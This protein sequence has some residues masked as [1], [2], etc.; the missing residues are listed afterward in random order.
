MALDIT[1]I[2]D[3][4]N[5]YLNSI[6]STS[7]A[8]SE[9]QSIDTDYGEIFKKYLTKAVEDESAN[10]A[11]AVNATA[12]EALAQTGSNLDIVVN[13]SLATKINTVF[14]GLDIQSEIAENMASHTVDIS[15]QIAQNIDSHSRLDEINAAALQIQEVTEAAETNTD[16]AGS[17]E[18]SSNADAYSG[19]LGTSALQRLA[20]SSYFSANLIQSSLID[21][22]AEDNNSSMSLSDLNNNSL[23]N[24][25]LGTSTGN[26]T[27]SDYTTALINSYKSS[28][29]TSVFGE[30]EI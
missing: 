23:L 3:V 19:L 1:K 15:S 6:S 25:T 24:N 22:D 8:V 20:D 18:S 10:A 7:K 14:Q 5:A 13:D 26:L 4:V 2:T 12:D 21:S 28:P 30:F 17:G 11:N 27:T 29:I 9:T 16:S